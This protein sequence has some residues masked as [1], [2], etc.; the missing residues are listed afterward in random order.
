MSKTSHNSR[1][2]LHSVLTIAYFDRLGM[3]PLT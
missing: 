1:I 3:P 2:A